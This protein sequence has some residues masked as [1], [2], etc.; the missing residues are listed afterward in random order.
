MV[1]LG[2]T[3]PEGGRERLKMNMS[4]HLYRLVE[5]VPC[6]ITSETMALQIIFQQSSVF[7]EIWRG[8]NMILSI[9]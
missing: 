4:G 3:S 8:Y 9:Y 1:L 2:K 5:K 7:V 6:L